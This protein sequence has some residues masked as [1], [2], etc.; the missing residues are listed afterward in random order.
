MCD[1]VWPELVKVQKSKQQLATQKQAQIDKQ[2]D[3]QIQTVEK[4]TADMLAD[5]ESVK[6]Q[7]RELQI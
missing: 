1:F 4:Q 5:N 3:D 2:K 7:I 6:R